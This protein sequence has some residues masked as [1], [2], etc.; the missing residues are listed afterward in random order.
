MSIPAVLPPF[1]DGFDLPP[2]DVIFGT[3]RRMAAVRQQV[4]SAASADIP[5]FIGGESGTGKELIAKLVHSRSPW[6]KGTFVKVSCPAIPE[7]LLESELFGYERGAFTGAYAAK[8]GRVE[9]AEGGTLFLDEIG[10]LGP[11]MQAKLL[12]LLQDGHFCRIG[13]RRDRRV[14]V[15]VLCATNRR[16]ARE[17][18]RGAFRA[19]LFYRINVLAIS[20]PTLAERREDIPLLIDYLVNKYSAQYDKVWPGNIRQLENLVKRFVIVGREESLAEDD[21]I[22]GAEGNPSNGVEAKSSVVERAA[23]SQT[24]LKETL[25]QL[26]REVILRALNAN[27]W[28]RRLAARAL[29]ISY[30]TLL[31]KMR[32]AGIPSTRW[33]STDE[34]SPKVGLSEARNS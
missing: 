30:T 23:D 25:R 34:E 5:V 33:S 31:Y 16:L 26:E 9:T 32:G 19:D 17:V 13:A 10:E 4:E 15:R 6:H 3:T 11:A 20:L 24:G 7:T 29:Q 21:A 1:E 27:S 28:N 14:T 22:W 2:E 8:P 12:Q 18:H